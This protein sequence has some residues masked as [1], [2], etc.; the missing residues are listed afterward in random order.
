[1]T[2]PVASLAWTDAAGDHETRDLLANPPV[3]A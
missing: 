3:A 1:N 2:T